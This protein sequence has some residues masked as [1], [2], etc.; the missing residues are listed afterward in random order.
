M[1]REKRC[2]WDKHHAKL[3]VDSGEYPRAGNA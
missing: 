2:L 1:Q 3:G